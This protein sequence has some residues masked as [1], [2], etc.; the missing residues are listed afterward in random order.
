MAVRTAV[1]VFCMQSSWYARRADLS[2]AYLVLLQDPL[3]L[4]I[5][6]RRFMLVKA[7]DKHSIRGR[8]YRTRDHISPAL[9]RR[10][11]NLTK[12]DSD[13][14]NWLLGPT[15]TKPLT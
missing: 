2:R 3:P 6:E 13:D 11:A 15:N 4:D 12:I 9:V 14:D 7:G 8:V 5:G 1:L 10:G